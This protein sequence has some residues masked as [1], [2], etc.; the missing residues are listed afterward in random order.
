MSVR[1]RRL[2]LDDLVQEFDCGDEPLNSYLKKHA[3]TNQRQL[4]IGITYVGVDDSAPR[5]V[6]GYFTL[7]SASAQR[8]E[9]AGRHFRGLPRYD[10]PLILIARLAVDHRLQGKGLGHALLSEALRISLGVSE[11]IGCRGIVVDAY[12][13]AVDW[14]Q[15]YGF[16]P[17]SK[18]ASVG[19][20]KMYLDMR[21]LRAA[22]QRK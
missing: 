5:T 4:S 2:E 7:A 17:L 21:T 19:A 11:Q 18:T 13:S 16:V 14:Y 12:P 20:R 6:I 22:Q 15:Q 10:V 1:I 9:A 8:E 3:W